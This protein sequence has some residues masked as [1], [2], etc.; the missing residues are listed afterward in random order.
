MKKLLLT[1]DVICAEGIS[2]RGS[3]TEVNMVPFTGQA[4][5]ESFRGRII[6][7]GVDTQKTDLQSGACSLSAR[8]MLQGIDS[9]G[10]PCRIFIENSVRDEAG[11]HPM[12][13]TDSRALAD[14]ESLPLTASVDGTDR[15]VVVRIYS[16]AEI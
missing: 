16:D 13:V 4:F 15:G 5:G 1:I 7:T 10:A 8:Y 11:W 9:E 14:W 12:L 6:G 2:V 3:S